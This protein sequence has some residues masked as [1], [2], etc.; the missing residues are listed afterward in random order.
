MHQWLIGQGYEVNA[1]RVKRLLRQMGLEAIYPK[2]RTSTPAP[3]H[4]IYPYLLRGLPIVRPNQVWGTD[5]TRGGF[6]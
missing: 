4:Q 5:I 3:G 1:K 6:G 2:P